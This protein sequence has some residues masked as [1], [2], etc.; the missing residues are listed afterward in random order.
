MPH[1]DLKYSA[2]L[3]IDGAAIL[4]DVEATIQAHDAS[5]GMCKG[6]AYPAEVFHHTH[7]I[8]EISMLPKVHRDQAFMDALL[9]DLES[10]I[11]EHLKVPCAFSLAIAFSPGTYV[12]NMHSG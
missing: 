2:D 4:A 12:T 10:C 11:K 9:R 3:N 1:A 5:S 8:V 7:L 6:R